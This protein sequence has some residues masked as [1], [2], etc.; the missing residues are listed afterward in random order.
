[1]ADFRR[2][3]VQVTTGFPK[4]RVW[5]DPR[6]IVRPVPVTLPS[7]QIVQVLAENIRSIPS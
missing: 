3:F 4:Q 6:D 1:M 7:G 5:I 2:F